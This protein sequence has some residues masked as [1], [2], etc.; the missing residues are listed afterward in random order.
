[1][2]PTLFAK[3]HAPQ[4]TAVVALVTYGIARN[5]FTAG[6]VIAGVFVSVIHMLHPWPAFFW[7]LTIFVFLG[8]LVTKV[9]RRHG[10]LRNS[11][12]SIQD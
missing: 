5:K 3:Q 10:L 7:L 4:I 9:S 1:M 2:D 12:P 6:G 11:K 8:T